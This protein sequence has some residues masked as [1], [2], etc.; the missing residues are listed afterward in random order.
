MSLVGRLFALRIGTEGIRKQRKEV[1]MEIRRKWLSWR[2]RSNRTREEDKSSKGWRLIK[3]NIGAGKGSAYEKKTN[4]WRRQKPR[5]NDRKIPRGFLSSSS[6]LHLIQSGRRRRRRRTGNQ[7]CPSLVGDGSTRQRY[8]SLW[9]PLW[10]HYHA[11]S[12]TDI[13]SDWGEVMEEI[14]VQTRSLI[15]HEGRP[16]V[17]GEQGEPGR[18]FLLTRQRVCLIEYPEDLSH[19]SNNVT[20]TM[21]S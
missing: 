11:D 2:P 5:A 18:L 20:I 10:H 13:L 19:S 3:E 7:S 17:T 9:L 12:L 15:K 16:D 4:E 1:G 14:L 8:A 6:I 21:D